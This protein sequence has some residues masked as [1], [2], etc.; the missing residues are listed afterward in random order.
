MNAQGNI[1]MTTAWWYFWTF[2]FVV[3]GASFFAIAVV[4]MVR[5][6][7][8]LRKMIAHITSRRG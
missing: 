4:V 8:D 1:A 2:C 5:G 3:A 7:G 6:A